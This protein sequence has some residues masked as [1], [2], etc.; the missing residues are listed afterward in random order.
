MPTHL[1]CLLPRGNSAAPAAPV[2]VLDV[3]PAEAWVADT[4]EPLL[5]RDARVAARATIEHDR[6]VSGSLAQGV[7][8][9]PAALADPYPDDRAVVADVASHAEEIS[10]AFPAITGM[11][12]MTTI[13]ALHD[14]PPPPGDVP[15]RGR[16]YI[17]QL[18]SA[19]A[20]AAAIGD[21]IAK[22]MSERFP[23]SARRADGARIAISHLI[24]ATAV[25]YYRETARS[26]E[27]DGYRIVVD[28]PRAPYS[29]AMFAPRRGLITP[30][31]L[32]STTLRAERHDSGEPDHDESA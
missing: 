24:P 29:F 9:V 21:R 23:D 12:E 13:I 10:A 1:Y 27:G 30:L 26:S 22:E 19:P 18:R 31:W 4:G 5:S 25:G 14:E 16:A 15:G 17:E 3:G 8:P 28:G 6:V 7:T 32:G 11:V 20:R 2:R